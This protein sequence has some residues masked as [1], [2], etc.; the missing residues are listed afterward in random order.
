V[1]E[2]VYVSMEDRKIDVKNVAQERVSV[3]MEDGNHIANHVGEF[4][5]VSMEKFEVVAKYVVRI[6]VTSARFH[7]WSCVPALRWHT[8][9]KKSSIAKS[10]I[11]TMKYR[12]HCSHWPFKSRNT[13]PSRS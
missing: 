8:N 12:T 13:S 7:Q 2:T 5:Y 10:L 6:C 4:A 3:C 1:A 11:W 9:G